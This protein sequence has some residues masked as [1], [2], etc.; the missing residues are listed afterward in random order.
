MPKPNEQEESVAEIKK[1]LKKAKALSTV[2]ESDGG[3]IILA[4]F[5]D[6]ILSNFVTFTDGSDKFTLEDFR[7]LAVSTREKLALVRVITRAKD[8]KKFLEE[9]LKSALAQ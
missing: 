4:G 6:D 9:E 7:V 1:D 5:L 8:N 2:A 3:K